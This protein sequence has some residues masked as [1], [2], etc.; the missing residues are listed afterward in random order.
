MGGL[1]PRWRNARFG[2]ETLSKFFMKVDI[3]DQARIRAVPCR[4]CASCGSEGVYLYLEQQ[5]RLFGANGL[6][7]LKKCSNRKCGLIWL[8]PMPLEEDIGKAYAN[9]YTH[10]APV[11]GRKAGLLKQILRLMKRGYHAAKY[12]YRTG[13][14][15]FWVRYLGSLLYFFPI[16][17]GDVDAEVRFL[18]AVP[19]GRL[20]DVGCGSGE[21]LASMQKLGWQVL[22]VDFDE[23]AVKIARQEGLEVRTGSLEEQ[24]FPD[25]SF[26][27]VTLSHVIEHVP[28]PAR[29]LAECAR[30]L[31]P[32]GKLVLLTPNAA[33]LGHR[34][35]KKHWRGLEPPRHLH[36]FS[37]ESLPSMLEVAGFRQVT[38]YPQIAS[39]VLYESILLWR[40]LWGSHRNARRNWPAWS[41][42]RFIS[43][44]ELSLIKFRPSVGDC[45]A[46]VAAKQ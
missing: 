11:S 40:G 36:I 3:T 46:A 10:A 19:K 44:L 45:I 29:T 7:N 35:F 28:D 27:A 32:A 14:E 20:L 8:D 24:G 9:Y 5:D 12:G 38:V 21:W 2:L 31:K 30:I 1:R 41:L 39:S 37:I 23:N 16:R 17:R 33:S 34:L 42:A 18:H 6:W 25:G 13:S 26:D 15:P 43:L 4:S 22:G